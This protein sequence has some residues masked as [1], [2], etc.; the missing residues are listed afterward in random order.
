MEGETSMRVAYILVGLGLAMSCGE[1]GSDSPAAECTGGTSES[2]GGE[3]AD[4]GVPA[5][6]GGRSSADAGVAGAS[7][8]PVEIEQGGAAGSPDHEPDVGHGGRGQAGTPPAV[9]EAGAGGE[10]SSGLPD[11]LPSDFEGLALWLEATDDSC[12]YDEF[13]QVSLWSDGSGNANHAAQPS[14]TA[15]PTLLRSVLNGRGVLHFDDEPSTLSVPDSPSLRFAQGDFAYLFVMR[16]S[17]D[18]TPTQTYTGAGSVLAK[19][20]APYPYTGVAFFANQQSVYGA[21]AMRRFALQMEL[22][23]P[24]ALSYRDHLNDDVFRLYCAR[25]VGSDVE[26][27]INGDFDARVELV[28]PLDVDAYGSSM[29]IGGW[30]GNQFRGD[31][32]EIV[33]VG[34]STSPQ[35][36]AR[37]ERGLMNKYALSAD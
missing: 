33:V 4:G 1:S 5:S 13:D 29:S 2:S 36:F 25:R 30:A 23:G 32:A 35:D 9:G 31:I 28:D 26:L 14:L 27:R 6:A 8:G 11:L 20:I 34:G 12:N 21:P 15:Q 7:M 16:W 3:Y 19:V 17:N 18:H 22:G 37:L 10:E 24:L